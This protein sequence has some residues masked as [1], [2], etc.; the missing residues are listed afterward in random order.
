MK[1]LRTLL[2]IILCSV[3]LGLI[4]S[5]AGLRRQIEELLPL[6]GLTDTDA[7]TGG[8]GGDPPGSGQSENG[9]GAENSGEEISGNGKPRDAAGLLINRSPSFYCYSCL[10]GEEQALYDLLLEAA[11]DPMSTEAGRGLQ[12][13]LDPAGEDFHERFMRVCD[14]LLYDHPEFFWLYQGKSGF[15]FSYFSLPDAAGSWTIHASLTKEWPEYGSKMALFNAAVSDFLSDIDTE[16]PDAAVAMAIHDKLID[17]V[18]YGDTSAAASDDSHTAFGALVA[19]SSG[20]PCTA[21]CAGYAFAYEYLLQQCGIPCTMVFGYAGK[22]GEEASRHA[23]NLVCLD[24]EWYEV[25]PTWNDREI[26][27]EYDE[28]AWLLLDDAMNDTRY[29]NR[30]RHY[31]FNVTT[32]TITC[33]NPD[34]SWRYEGAGG[35]VTFLESSVHIRFDYKERA[36]TGDY[37]ADM[38]PVA[39][40]T[41]YSYDMLV[42]NDWTP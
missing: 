2:S 6:E 7:G 11:S 8:T 22:N 21:V 9:K 4:F 42:N 34:D 25:D 31:L 40:G 3:F 28:E 33:F 36:E 37:A 17:M 41:R 39:T 20:N 18:S 5:E 35:W 12:I 15:Q 26:W 14:A 19:D 24:G 27:R 29:W 16:A 10:N 23:W 38:P 32:E 13:H 30:I 1:I